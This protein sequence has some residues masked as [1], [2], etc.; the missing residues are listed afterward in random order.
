MTSGMGNAGGQRKPLTNSPRGKIHSHPDLGISLTLSMRAGELKQKSERLKTAKHQC[1]SPPASCPSVCAHPP[2]HQGQL[3]SSYKSRSQILQKG[4]KHCF[5]VLTGN[6][7]G[8]LKHRSNMVYHTHT[9]RSP[10]AS[11]G[12]WALLRGT[13]GIPCP[14]VQCFRGP[15]VSLPGTTHHGALQL[16]L[17]CS[18]H[19]EEMAVRMVYSGSF[20]LPWNDAFPVTT[21]H[22]LPCHV[23]PHH[24]VS[25]VTCS[26]EASR[27]RLLK[28]LLP[29]WTAVVCDAFLSSKRNRGFPRGNE[30]PSVLPGVPGAPFP[31]AR[32]PLTFQSLRGRGKRRPAAR[33]EGDSGG[34]VGYL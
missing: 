25:T 7:Q 26:A 32:E 4:V 3:I 20:S 22:G 17:P 8:A 12:L 21:Q 16:S 5:G 11:S 10:W 23:L 14:G 28:S 34:A 33:E 24:G 30:G 18:L 27:P 2:A 13:P 1:F 6:Q 19:Q 31:S 9:R 29:G 15:L